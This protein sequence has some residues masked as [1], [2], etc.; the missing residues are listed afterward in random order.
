[1]STIRGINS[2]AGIKKR[3]SNIEIGKERLLVASLDD[4]IKSK[5]AA[6]KQDLATLPLLLKTNET[7]KKGKT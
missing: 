1:M 3:A 5:K 7:L 6:R 2:F 4:I